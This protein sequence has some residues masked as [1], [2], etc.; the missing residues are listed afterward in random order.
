MINV[1]S[2]NDPFDSAPVLFHWNVKDGYPHSKQGAFEGEIIWLW[3]AFNMS[4]YFW[5]MVCVRV[6]GRL[7]DV[8]I[9]HCYHS[10][11]MEIPKLH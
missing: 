9:L 2:Q 7:L 8:C 5:R 6:Q 3:Q 11:F 4:D 1:L 10:P